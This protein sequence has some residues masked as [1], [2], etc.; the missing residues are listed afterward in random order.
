MYRCWYFSYACSSEACYSVKQHMASCPYCVQCV[1]KMDV[2]AADR[3]RDERLRTEAENNGG[4]CDVEA[5]KISKV[6]GAESVSREP[7]TGNDVAKFCLTF[8]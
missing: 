4:A 7:P 5:E 6:E 8:P 3:E 2:V 1:K